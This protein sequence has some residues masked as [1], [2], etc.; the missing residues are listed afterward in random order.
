MERSPVSRIALSEPTTHWVEQ[1]YSSMNR[2]LLAGFAACALMLTP[3]LQASAMPMATPNAIRADEA[4]SALIQ[5][6]GGGHH[7]G[8]GHHYGWGGGRGHH[9]GWR[10]RR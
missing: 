8:R 2:T 9:Y 6:R 7:G 5:V 1:G 4:N 3:I 10:H